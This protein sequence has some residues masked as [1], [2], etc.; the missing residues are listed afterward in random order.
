LKALCDSIWLY[1]C[2]VLPPRVAR[3]RSRSSYPPLWGLFAKLDNFF[4]L[5]KLIEEMNSS[6]AGNMYLGR[7]ERKKKPGKPAGTIQ[8]NV[9]VLPD[10]ER[11]NWSLRG[12]TLHTTAG[13]TAD[14][15][16]NEMHWSDGDVWIRPRGWQPPRPA[17]VGPPM[18]APPPNQPY[19]PQVGPPSGAPPSNQPY[20]P[21]V[22]PPS[23]P[24]PPNNPYGVG[25]PAGAPPPNQPYGAP[26]QPAQNPNYAATAPPS[27]PP[28]QNQP[29]GV[30]QPNYGMQNQPYRPN[31]GPP[32]GAPPPSQPYGA[33]Q[34]YRPPQQSYG[35]TS[36]PQG[37]QYMPQ[38]QQQSAPYGAAPLTTGPPMN[39]PYGA[40]PP[41]PNYGAPPPQQNYNPY[42][43][44]PQQQQYRPPNQAYASGPPQGAPPPNQPYAQQSGGSAPYGAS[45]QYRRQ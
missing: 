10:G 43:A 31:V 18:G 12:N 13:F 4:V 25:P 2:R 23:G 40:Q 33:Q 22:G 7:W 38:Q 11:Q 37:N 5:T 1:F 16:G 28:P 36:V 39:Q 27:G 14:I 44:P 42:G 26:Q 35:M 17:H 41:R 24:P 30:S 45:A 8:A 21:Q 15:V 6:Q 9:I 19:R 3:C 29:Y 20:R 34:P 32:A